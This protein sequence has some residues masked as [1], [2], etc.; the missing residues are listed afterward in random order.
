MPLG[1][2]PLHLVVILAVVLILLGPRKLPE[3][4]SALG[5]SIREFRTGLSEVPEAFRAEVNHATPPATTTGTAAA[6][7]IPPI[8]P[9][10]EPRA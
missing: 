5:K 9:A 4:G 7:P 8:P 2:T 1:L 10:G 6:E 3:I